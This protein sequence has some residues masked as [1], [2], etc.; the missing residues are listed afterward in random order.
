[1]RSSEKIIYLKLSP[2]NNPSQK[3]IVPAQEISSEGTCKFSLKEVYKRSQHGAILDRDA[4]IKY[5]STETNEGIDNSSKGGDSKVWG[6][7]SPVEAG[8]SV[9]GTEG[10]YIE[11][12]MGWLKNDLRNFNRLSCPIKLNPKEATFDDVAL[13]ALLRQ[14]LSP[15]TVEKNLRYARFMETHP[16]VPVDFRNP[17]YENFIRHM[18]YREQVEGATPGALKHEWDA[19]KMFLRAYGMPIWDYKLPPMPRSRKRLLP[20]PDIVNRF[21]SHRYSRDEYENALYQY[22]F[23][24]SFLIGWRVPS[25]IVSM[26]V[27]DVIIEGRR[28]YIVITETKKRSSQRTLIPEPAIISSKVHKSFK[29]WIDHWRPKVENQYSGDALYLQPSGKPFTVNHLRRKL[30]EHGKKVWKHFQ[31]YD[32]R[33]WCAIARLIKT[34]VESGRFDIFHVQRW[35]GHEDIKTTESYLRYAEQYYQQLPIDWIAAALRPSLM[36]AGKSGGK[37]NREEYIEIQISE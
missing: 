23:F 34:K 37:R 17:N 3:I 13:H 20:Y 15:S 1:M 8:D 4:E 14:R 5:L 35:L 19:M 24:H 21:F 27:D 33:H 30:S 29:N 7:V 31:P 25:E 2:I 6:A 16:V 22:L 28:G 9:I 36:M 32:M 10:W 26:T 11:Q 18:D 12:I